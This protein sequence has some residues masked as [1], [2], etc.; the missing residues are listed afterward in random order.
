LST[1][2][3]RWRGIRFRRPERLIDETVVSFADDAGGPSGLNVTV[4]IDEIGG[5]QAALDEYV[6]QQIN[7][8]RASVPG[9]KLGKREERTVNGRACVMVH[10]SA[11]SSNQGVMSQIQA[12]V[13]IGSE[14]VIITGSSASALA[15][16]TAREVE[17][18]LNTL[19]EE[20]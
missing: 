17:G 5:A 15:D 20:R 19:E 6:T 16:R 1:P 8:L 10:Q 9:Y 2:D 12:Y 3:Y 13:R 7:E 14:V 11:R 4:A 18:I